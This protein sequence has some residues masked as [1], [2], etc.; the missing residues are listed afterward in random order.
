MFCA[1]VDGEV[2]APFAVEPE[3]RFPVGVDEPVPDPDPLPDP[4]P[5]PL[6]C[7]A[8]GVGDLVGVGFFT[9]KL[10]TPLASA[11]FVALMY[12]VTVTVPFVK[13]LGTATVIEMCLE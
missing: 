1:A 3:F 5:D 13:L 9:V 2:F 4:E 10:R 12:A 8:F 6:E 7:V 11:A